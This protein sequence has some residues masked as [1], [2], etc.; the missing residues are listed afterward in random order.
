MLQVPSVVAVGV[1][2]TP[3]RVIKPLLEAAAAVLK[4][5]E[6]APLLLAYPNSGEG[7]VNRTGK[8]DGN[9][10]F[11]VGIYHCVPPSSTLPCQL[12]SLN[13]ISTFPCLLDNPV[14]A[15]LVGYTIARHCKAT[16]A[17]TM[18]DSSP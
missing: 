16:Q 13:C 5:Q 1:N 4:D 2:C 14:P 8:W 3:P 6:N 12:P 7:W 11:Q 10:D 17:G 18:P 9:S 15:R